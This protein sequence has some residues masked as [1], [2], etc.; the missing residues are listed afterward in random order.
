MEE[1]SAGCFS[2]R[3]SYLVILLLRSVIEEQIYSYQFNLEMKGFS[4]SKD[5]FEGMKNAKFQV[6]YA[7][8]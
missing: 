8:A 2:A 3:P 6:I 7:L 4:F 1:S 5:V